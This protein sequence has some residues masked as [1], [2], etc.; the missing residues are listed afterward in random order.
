MFDAHSLPTMM[1][2]VALFHRF[3]GTELEAIVRAGQT[4]QYARDETIFVEGELCAGLFVLLTGRVQLCKY[5]PQ[6]QVSIISLIDPVLMFNE[7][8]ALDRGP[9]P[10]TAIAAQEVTAWRVSAEDFAHMIL[11]HPELAL[12]LLQVLARRNRLLTHLYED[13]SFRPVLSR[14]AKLLML[15]SQDGMCAIERRRHPNGQMS[16]RISTVPEA[17]SRSL[18]LL[19]EAGLISCNEREIVVRDAAALG[20]VAESG[21]VAPA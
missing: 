6:G 3:S 1:R 17:F 19:R 20:R 10:V 5:G 9:N 18:R 11:R 4:R 21:E 8:A 7:V 14:V 15:L 12:G 2:H 16:A 13:L